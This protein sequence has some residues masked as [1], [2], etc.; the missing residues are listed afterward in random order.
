[1]KAKVNKIDIYIKKEND[2]QARIIFQTEKAM[3]PF[4]KTILGIFLDKN[5]STVADIDEV[6]KFI[7][8]VHS[9]GLTFDSEIDVR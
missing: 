2:H 1:M 8:W 4:K 6:P 5:N 9:H 7:Q 3:K